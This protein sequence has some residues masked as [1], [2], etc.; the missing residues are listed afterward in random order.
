LWEFSSSNVYHGSKVFQDGE[1]IYFSN[2][3]KSHAISIENSKMS[4]G[5]IYKMKL[6][7]SGKVRLNSQNSSNILIKDNWVYYFE[8]HEEPS[9]EGGTSTYNYLYR[10]KPDGSNPSK[11]SNKKISD[12]L[13]I[14]DTI[15]FR[16][17]EDGKMYKMKL[18]GTECIKFL[19]MYAPSMTT[20]GKYIYYIYT[21]PTTYNSGIY[22]IPI[23]GTDS[24]KLYE[25]KFYLGLEINGDYIYFAGDGI[26]K[27]KT[28]GSGF[29]KII[30]IAKDEMPSNLKVSKDKL[31]FI[32]SKF[33]TNPT[34]YSSNLDG[35]NAANLSETNGYCYITD[36]TASGDYIYYNKS[37]YTLS[38]WYRYKLQDGGE[39][40]FN[41]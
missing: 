27:I 17:Y 14:K 24:T 40:V 21:N 23:D 25:G 5:S 16:S 29:T 15:F 41:K 19:D 39:E 35:S 37:T 3:T 33:Y 1:W 6:D 22:K 10:M 20:D 9:T 18:D 26:F 38:E 4:D 7:G 34:L 12:M 28:D 8:N 36:I 31:Y 11:L 32:S 13:L 30:G 2:S